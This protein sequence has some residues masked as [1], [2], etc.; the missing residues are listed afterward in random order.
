MSYKG[1]MM[2]Y[3]GGPLLTK[4]DF[5]R[6]PDMDTRVALLEVDNKVRHMNYGEHTINEFLRS[7]DYYVV[8]EAHARKDTVVTREVRSNSRNKL[9]IP[10]VCD[11]LGI[12]CMT[13]FEMLSAENARFV[14][15]M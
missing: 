14:L 13:T 2:N 1:E 15:D 5:F 6:P 12:D 4:D 10:D 8:T 11:E 3:R 7:A 9:K